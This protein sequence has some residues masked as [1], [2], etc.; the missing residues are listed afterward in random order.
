MSNIHILSEPVH[1]GKSTLLMNWCG[2]QQSVAGVLMPD[3]DGSRKLYD[4]AAKKYYDFQVKDKQANST[5]DICK[6]SFDE[7]VFKLGKDI[8]LRAAKQKPEWLILD[9]VGK[10]EMNK[11]TGFEPA[12]K[13]L[14]DIYKHETGNAKL[15]LVIRDY[16]LE[17]SF[18]HYG[19]DQNMVL[20]KTF[21]L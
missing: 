12:V 17:Q 2:K 14:I 13:E 4:I 8:L 16:M 5:I 18:T 1:S 9:E 7:S 21:F 3:V 15:L 20:P 11:N 6:W 19:L 10:L